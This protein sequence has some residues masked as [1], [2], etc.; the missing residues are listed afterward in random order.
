MEFFTQINEFC[1][2]N[3]RITMENT[4]VTIIAITN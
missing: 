2:A 1:G 3:N 4:M